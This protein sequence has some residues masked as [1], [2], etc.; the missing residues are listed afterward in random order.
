L[1]ML[2]FPE[3]KRYVVGLSLRL[4]LVLIVY[5]LSTHALAQQYVHILQSTLACEG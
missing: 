2:F 5:F 1:E 4:R 3:F